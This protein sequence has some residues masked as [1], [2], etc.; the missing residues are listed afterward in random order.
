[1]NKILAIFIH[2]FQRFCVSELRHDFPTSKG[3]FPAW[4]MEWQL[5]D[6]PNYDDCWFDPS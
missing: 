5:I 3:F 6:V 4:D 1:M 2:N